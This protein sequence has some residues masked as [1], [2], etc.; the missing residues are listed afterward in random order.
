MPTAPLTVPATSTDAF[1]AYLQAR[2]SYVG[3]LATQPYDAFAPATHE[4]VLAVYDRN[5]NPRTNVD[6]SVQDGRDKLDLTDLEL[7]QWHW[8][9]A[10]SVDGLKTLT[11]Q[12][13]GSR[14]PKFIV[15]DYRDPTVEN[16]VLY[17]GYSL[18]LAANCYNEGVCLADL[19]QRP[20]VTLQQ[21]IARSESAPTRKAA[22]DRARVRHALSNLALAD[23]AA[24]T[25]EQAVTALCA[26]AQGRGQYDIITT[27]S[28]GD[29]YTPLRVD[30]SR[31]VEEL[32]VGLFNTPEGRAEFEEAGK[33]LRRAMDLP[34][35]G[36][37]LL[38]TIAK[39]SLLLLQK[40]RT[41]LAAGLDT[42]HALE[43]EWGPEGRSLVTRINDVLSNYLAKEL[44]RSV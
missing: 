4:D 9:L 23:I 29:G 6:E 39:A 36:E 7:R 2:L 27:R 33:E 42:N 38:A 31:S 37:D 13:T 14:P 24:M 35:N 12:H 32:V 21:L 1:A 44:L 34:G 19:P 28:P 43:A 30:D 26:E 41:T 10:E 25:P 17:Q 20:R 40:A 18:E 8:Q 3:W 22:M 5:C 11:A 15:E 16:H